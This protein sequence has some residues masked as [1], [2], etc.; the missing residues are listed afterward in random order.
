[1]CCIR[2]GE[3]RSLGN[4]AKQRRNKNIRPHI[5]VTDEKAV[6]VGDVPIETLI[7]LVRRE[8]RF[9]AAQ[10]VGIRILVKVG[11]GQQI[12]KIYRNRAE[13][14][15]GDDVARERRPSRSIGIACGR[16]EYWIRR[17]NGAEVSI[18]KSVV[19]NGC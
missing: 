19:R 8:W 5:R 3:R 10:V 17:S 18:A 2:S 16:I 14:T 13:M 1:M 9:A 12:Q 15:R 6:T 4:N 11:T 7:K